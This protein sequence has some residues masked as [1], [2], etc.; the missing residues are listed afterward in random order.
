MKTV[1]PY[2]LRMLLHTILGDLQTPSETHLDPSWAHGTQVKNPCTQY[3][4]FLTGRD[5]RDLGR[6]GPSLNL[7]R[8][9]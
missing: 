9:V 2:L 7:L 8:D 3:R 1:G 4:F 6:T 5:P